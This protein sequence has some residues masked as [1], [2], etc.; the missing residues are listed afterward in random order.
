ML[1]RRYI[2]LAISPD[3]FLKAIRAGMIAGFSSEV[4][5]ELDESEKADAYAYMNRF[6]TLFEPKVRERMPNI[7]EAYAQVYAREFSAEEL[8]AMIAFAQSPT[9]RH[10]LARSLE[11]ATD[12]AIQIQQQGISNDA[13]PIFLQIIKEQCAARTAKRIA[14]GDKKAKCPLANIPDTQAG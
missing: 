3:Q 8:Q 13:F 12:P 1:A 2:S 6:A 10:Y 5:S 7:M 9:G 11:L 4:D 14:M